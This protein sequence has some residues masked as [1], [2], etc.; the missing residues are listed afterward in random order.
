[1]KSMLS[2][3]VAIL[4]GVIVLVVSFFITPDTQSMRVTML[5]WAAILVGIA[6]LIGIFNLV[7]SHWKRLFSREKKDIYSLF[8]VI[9]FV[10]SAAAGLFLTPTDSNYQKIITAIQ[11]PVETALLAVLSVSLAYSAYRLLQRR[12]NFMGIIFVFSFVIFLILGSGLL[13]NIQVLPLIGPLLTLLPLAGA[14][15]LLLGIGLASLTAGI[16]ILF[17]ADRPYSG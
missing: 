7:S 14:R 9:A 17:G 4:S 1:M 8:L 3:I 10:A 5:S 12:K 6:A 13:G 16:R 2:T 11:V 15:G